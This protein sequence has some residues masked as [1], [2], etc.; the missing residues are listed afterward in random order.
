MHAHGERAKNATADPGE[1]GWIW[2]SASL[3]DKGSM[4]SSAFSASI[5]HELCHLC[6]EMIIKPS[7]Q[8]R[9][10]VVL[11]EPDVREPRADGPGLLRHRRQFYTAEVE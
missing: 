7:L 4:T 8:R 2:Q 10:T 6:R 5:S 9:L 11:C 3:S 1:V